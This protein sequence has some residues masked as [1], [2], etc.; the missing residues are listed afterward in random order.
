MKKNLIY[1]IVNV[2][3]CA[4]F[5]TLSVWVIKVDCALIIKV[6]IAFFMFESALASLLAAIKS[7][8]TYCQIK[9]LLKHYNQCNNNEDK[10]EWT[11]INK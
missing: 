8:I 4:T 10:K 3:L 2:I 5:T 11:K 7:L 6:I 9:K 1:F